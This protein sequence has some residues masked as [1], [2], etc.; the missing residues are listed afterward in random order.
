MK[1]VLFC[2]GWTEKK[3]LPAFLRRWLDSQLSVRVGIK[4]VRFDGWQELVKDAP[5]KAE[6]HLRAND[7]IAVIGLLDPLWTNL[8]PLK[9]ADCGRALRVGQKRHREESCG[10]SLLS[11]LR[12]PRS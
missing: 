9:Q 10:F 8:L 1:F 6:L 7:V 4:V 5:V 2:E 3:S 11:A 12:R